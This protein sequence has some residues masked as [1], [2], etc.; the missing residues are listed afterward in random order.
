M[1]SARGCRGLPCRVSP[2]G[3]L[4]INSRY[5]SPQIFAVNY[6]LRRLMVPRHPSCARIRLTE[7]LLPKKLASLLRALSRTGSSVYVAISTQFYSIVKEL[8]NDIHVFPAL[9]GSQTS[10][11]GG[12]WRHRAMRGRCKSGLRRPQPALGAG[13]VHHSRFPCGKASP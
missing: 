4:R 8:S 5:Q 1:C 11:R 12:M 9:P 2:F 7:T 3:Y 13:C 10:C 6:V